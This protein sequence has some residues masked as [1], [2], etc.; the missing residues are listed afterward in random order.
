M[1]KE[2]AE[3]EEPEKKVEI[4]GPKNGGGEWRE[5]HHGNQEKKQVSRRKCLTGPNA[6]ERASKLRVRVDK[7]DVTGDLGKRGFFRDAGGGGRAI[8]T[9]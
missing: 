6:I 7:E 8:V 9:G 5:C 3:K 4:E 1:F 2:K